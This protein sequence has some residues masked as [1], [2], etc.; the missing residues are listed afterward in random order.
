MKEHT[1]RFETRWHHSCIR[2]CWKTWKS[3]PWLHAQAK[4]A[5]SLFF[6]TINWGWNVLARRRTWGGQVRKLFLYRGHHK[7]AS[8]ADATVII[9]L[10][11]EML[12][13]K[14]EELG[15]SV[16]HSCYSSWFGTSQCF[17]WRNEFVCFFLS[18]A[19]WLTNYLKLNCSSQTFQL[20][21]SKFY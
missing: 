4:R 2:T 12:I 15:C 11:W 5:H 9:L 1:F 20:F 13:R 16:K 7:L 17:L 8:V 14:E 10:D 6:W 19:Q 21:K 3:C 18:T